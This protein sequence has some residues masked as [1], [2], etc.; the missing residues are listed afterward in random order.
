MRR[1]KQASIKL[2]AKLAVVVLVTAA[3]W[4]CADDTTPPP[5]PDAGL[6]GQ[7]GTGG[8]TSSTSTVG[9]FV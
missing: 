9:G 4:S 8:D 1:I 6:G 7:G 5:E 2:P 3:V